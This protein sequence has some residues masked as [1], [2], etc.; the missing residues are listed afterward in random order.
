[1]G[2][3]LR[4]IL[5]SIGLIV[6]GSQAFA[7]IQFCNNF[8]HPI[9]V[10]VAFERDGEWITEGWLE[11][12]KGQCVFDERH[13][14]LTSFYYY[15]ETEVYGNKRWTWGRAK[16]F[17]IRTSRFTIHN[18][19]RR[20]RGARFVR[21]AGPHSYKNPETIVTLRFDP[22]LTTTF[23]V[24]AERT[25]PQA[26]P[27]Q[28]SQPAQPSQP[29]T[30]ASSD[31]KNACENK[32][33]D[34]A[35]VGCSE[36]IGQNPNNGAA[37]FNRGIEYAKKRDYDRAIADFSRAITI[38]PG[39]ARAYNSRASSFYRG[40][41]DFHHAIADYTKAVDLD[42]GFS[43]ALINRGNVYRAIRAYDV[44]LKDLNAAIAMNA[45]SNAA[46]YYR[47]QVY[48]GLGRKDDA[49]ADY[50]LALGVDANDQD[51]KDALKRLG[52]AP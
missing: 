25:T 41:D 38:R 33:G 11:A 17:S 48:E 46:Y 16:E 22:D 6:C 52:V 28:P 12:P 29:P 51:S 4:A 40:K 30:P 39:D 13:P 37:F 34:E 45:K 10:A 42:P 14:D 3:V 26:Q 47:A 50:R 23:I 9:A 2:A 44:A 49:I 1:M 8:A 24:P 5:A 21:F 15:G 43:G 32:S 19:D 31:A 27:S 36:L 18:A 35:I 20:Q 7:K